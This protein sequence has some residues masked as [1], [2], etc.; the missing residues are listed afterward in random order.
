MRVLA[1][2]VCSLLVAF[3]FFEFFLCDNFTNVRKKR[4]LNFPPKANMALTISL[5]KAIASDAPPSPTTRI[6]TIHELDV[7]FPL[8]HEPSPFKLGT[9]S[10]GGL[11][12]HN[13]G[14]QRREVLSNLEGIFDIQG[15]SGR[16]CILKAMCEAKSISME[17]ED[18]IVV[19]ILLSIFKNPYN[20]PDYQITDMSCYR[21]HKECPVSLF[22]MAAT[23]AEQ[24]I[25]QLNTS[26]MYNVL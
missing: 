12:V 4:Y 15:Y 1:K 18:D 14:R 20:D 22:D 17:P 13:L 26:V 25:Q 2:N 19:D 21:Y 11:H 8:P 5:L 7:F 24:F 9:A 6:V 23:W 16:C 3:S 10:L